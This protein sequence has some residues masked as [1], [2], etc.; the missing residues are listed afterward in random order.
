MKVFRRQ[1][2]AMTNNVEPA[3]RYPEHEKQDAPVDIVQKN[4][5]LYIVRD[6]TA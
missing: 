2:T 3:Q 1:A 4:G 5:R 6:V